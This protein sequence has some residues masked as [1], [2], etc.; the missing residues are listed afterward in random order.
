MIAT[1]RIGMW[2]SDDGEIGTPDPSNLYRYVGNNP[3][4]RTDPTGLYETDIHFYMTYYLSR[5][6][7]LGDPNLKNTQKELRQRGENAVTPAYVIA[8][9]A[10]H[11]DDNRLTTPIP[12]HIGDVNRLFNDDI[13]F[14][15]FYAVEIE[16]KTLGNRKELIQS[17]QQLGGP[18]RGKIKGAY[19][20]TVIPLPVTKDSKYANELLGNTMRKVEGTDQMLPNSDAM[21]GMALHTYEDSWSH[22]GFQM[23]FGHGAAKCGGHAPDLPWKEP[24]R[25][26]EMAQQVYL[27]LKDYAEKKYGIKKSVFEWSEIKEEVEGLMKTGKDLESPQYDQGDKGIHQKDLENRIKA[28]KEA[29]KKRFD[30]IEVEYQ[31]KKEND[32]RND[33]W[34]GVFKQSIADIKPDSAPFVPRITDVRVFVELVKEAYTELDKRKDAILPAQERPWLDLLRNVYQEAVKIK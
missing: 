18:E 34:F 22:A 17:L 28:W 20:K 8:W 32:S 15:H 31:Y 29:I 16:V 1:N 7:G 3:T 27:K 26:T 33:E 2:I 11:V 13:L 9:F 30:G 12:M 6:V 10:Q 5:A 4:N 24:E 14:W 21:F 25:A 23:P 19:Y